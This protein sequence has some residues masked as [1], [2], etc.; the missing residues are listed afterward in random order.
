MKLRTAVAAGWAA[1]AA[2]LSRAESRATDA[3]LMGGDPRAGTRW[4]RRALSEATALSLIVSEVMRATDPPPELTIQEGQAIGARASEIRAQDN[5][6]VAMVTLRWFPPNLYRAHGYR[7]KLR[8]DVERLSA[9]AESGA[10]TYVAALFVDLNGI[11]R[12]EWIRDLAA[13]HPHVDIYGY[14]GGSELTVAC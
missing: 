8:D 10:A 9:L 3:D 11:V 6:S 14:S 13:A 2:E 12:S 1:L 4:P 7:L 5:R